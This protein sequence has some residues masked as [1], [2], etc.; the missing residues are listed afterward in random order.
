MGGRE[1]LGPSSKNVAWAPS[2]GP[3][4]TETHASPTPDH[5][6]LVVFLFDKEYS[7]FRTSSLLSEDY[8]RRATHGHAAQDVVTKEVQRV[9][10]SIQECELQKRRLRICLQDMWE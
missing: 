7:K 5:Q 2:I 8:T 10:R 6:P 1:S 3:N 9:L 4:P